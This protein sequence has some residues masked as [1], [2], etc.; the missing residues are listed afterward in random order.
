MGNKRL[1]ENQE[2]TEKHRLRLFVLSCIALTTAGMVFSIRATVMEDMG[3]VFSIPSE[4]V[5]WAVGAAFLAFAISVFV[6]SPL[7][8]Y[9]GMGRLLGLA[10]ICFIA[11][12]ALVIFSPLLVPALGLRPTVV[13]Y[14]SWFIVGTGHG[15]VEAVINPLVATLY[16]DDKT[17]KLNVLHAWWPGGLVI[18][19]VIA[20]LL[21]SS[22]IGG[23]HGWQVRLAVI[24]VPSLIFGAMLLGERFPATERVQSG[25]SGKEMLREAL[26]PLFIIWFL[27]MW[28]TAA[29]ELGPGQWVDATL[30]KTVGFQGIWLLVYGSALMFVFRHFAGPLAHKLSPVGLMWFSS[31]LAGIGLYAISFAKS[32]LTGLVSA[33][34]WYI[35]VCYMWPT[36]LGVC[37]ERFPRGGAFLL[38]LMGSA[39]NLSTQFVLPLMGKVYDTY[40]QKALPAGY[41]LQEVISKAATDPKSKYYKEMLEQARTQAAPVAFRY[42]AALGIVL[43]VVFGAIWISD[44]LKGGYK[45]EK[46]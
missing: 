28:L 23:E 2:I 21:R 16:R 8:D 13:L 4:S 7:C 30:T 31:L 6:G 24:V 11:G 36:M 32:P 17:H 27:M 43:I 39:G 33:T 29:M 15:L 26:K 45:A 12:I 46:I 14:V 38:G 41:K 37:S 19:G 5:G 9:L 22:G 20:L 1:L 42:V 18:G 34:I 40:A 44:Y 10:C 25:V 35:G 3:R